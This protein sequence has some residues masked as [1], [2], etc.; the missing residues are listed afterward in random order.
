MIGYTY[1][2]GRVFNGVQL[3]N[4][5]YHQFDENDFQGRILEEPIPQ[6]PALIDGVVV[7]A[8]DEIRQALEAE[9][10]AQ[11]LAINGERWA[12]ENE[13]LTMCDQLTGGTSKTK[14]G[15]AE[16][17]TIIT[18]MQATDPQTAMV[19]ALKLLTLN[20]ALVR[21]GGVM[22]WDDCKWHPEVAS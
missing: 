19:L 3:V 15:F 18:A 13:Y 11:E 1:E 5:T 22:W 8:G 14:L 4:V 10:K 6:T 20:A 21:T 9:Q 2:L 7:D 17:Q 12:Y 16:L